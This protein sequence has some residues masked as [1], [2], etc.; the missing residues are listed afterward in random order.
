MFLTPIKEKF[1][2]RQLG[3]CSKVFVLPFGGMSASTPPLLRYKLK[4]DVA[5]APLFYSLT[6][7]GLGS[8]CCCGSTAYLT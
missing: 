4:N 2:V 1:S 5:I 7:V 3:M 8:S 6:L